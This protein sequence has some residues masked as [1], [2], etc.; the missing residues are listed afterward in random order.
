MIAREYAFREFSLHVSKKNAA[1]V[2]AYDVAQNSASGK[3]VVHSTQRVQ[4][5]PL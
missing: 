2:A 4:E 3:L 5:H 1:C